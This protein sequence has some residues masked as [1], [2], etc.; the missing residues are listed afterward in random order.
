MKNRPTRKNKGSNLKQLE[1]IQR[2]ENILRGLREDTL[3][4]KQERYG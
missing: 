3:S 4:A 2:R 1:I